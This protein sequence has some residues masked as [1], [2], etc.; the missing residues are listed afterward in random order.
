MSDL[1]RPWKDHVYAQF[2]RV[3]KALASPRR[4]EL[5]DL[6]SQGPKTVETLAHEIAVSVA[7]VSQHLQ[8]LAQAQLVATQKSGKF[9]IYRLA[10]PHVADLLDQIHGVTEELSAEVRELRR[11]ALTDR[12]TMAP[13]TA[14]EL[15]RLVSTGE[16]YLID[17]RPAAEY[18]AGHLPGAIS[19][20]LEDV[21]SHFE[22]WQDPRPVIAYCRGRYCLYARDAVDALASL[23]ITARR[24]D[25]TV[26]DW[27]LPEQAG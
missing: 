22:K 4:L 6:L 27:P 8:I 25:V 3:G 5:L 23:G 10:S 2:A 19:V 9:V 21:T 24:T 14:D 26:R 16:V 11:T 18:A 20:P 12:D 17:V 15:Q 13:V 1:H 7:N